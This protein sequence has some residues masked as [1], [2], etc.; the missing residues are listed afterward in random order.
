MEIL[1]FIF[2]LLSF[3]L[4]LFFNKK[5]RTEFLYALNIVLFGL[6]FLM[7]LYIFIKI[8]NLDKDLP[9]FFYKL[10][11]YDNLLIDWSLRFDLFVS[12]LTV[13]VM[14]IGLLLAIYSI[15]FSTNK[16]INF[17]INSNLSLSVFSVLALI[18]SNNLD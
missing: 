8:M 6:A 10:I 4:F 11:K 17:Q 18:T 7:S 5:I 13:L 16:S 1:L 15:N 14:L 12:G 3:L 2:P 9:L